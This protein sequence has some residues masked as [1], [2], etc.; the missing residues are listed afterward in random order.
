M[1][2]QLH[3]FI[4]SRVLHLCLFGTGLQQSA[5]DR[6]SMQLN[7]QTPGVRGIHH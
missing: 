6:D 1:G 4:V 7:T 3:Q 5:L 2:L